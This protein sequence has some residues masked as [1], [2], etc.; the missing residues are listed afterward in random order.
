MRVLQ[1]I[2]SAGQY[3]AENLLLELSGA[4][5]KLNCEVKVLAI[6]NRSSRSLDVYRLAQLRGLDAQFI[7]H[8]ARFDSSTVK[9]IRNVIENNAIEIVHS[10]GYKSD[11]YGLWAVRKTGAGTVATCHGWPGKNLSLE[12]YYALDKLILRRFDCLVPVSDRVQRILRA[13]GVS[14]QRIRYVSNGVDT[15]RFCISPL[16]ETADSRTRK[17]VGVVAR[18]SPEKGIPFLFRAIKGVLQEFPKTELCLIGDGPERSR[19]EALAAE[20]GIGANVSFWGTQTDMPGVYSKLD[21]FVLPSLYEGLPMALLEAMASG[22]PVIATKVGNIPEVLLRDRTGI[23]VEPGDAN[24]LK[25]ALLHYLR[26]PDTA[27]EFG[28]NA[29]ER[30]RADYSAKSMAQKYLEIYQSVLRQRRLAS[31]N[32]EREINS[33]AHEGKH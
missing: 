11:F 30:I 31:Q 6:E 5:E 26:D 7:P 12:M 14:E 18:L 8:A 1:L 29:M 16:D 32:L 24:A 33:E 3:G 23:L 17:R 13:W 22:R 9:K 20:L 4:L 19:L 2:S 25:D 21:V 15:D 10:H 28:R 27:R